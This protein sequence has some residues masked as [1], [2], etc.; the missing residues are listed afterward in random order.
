MV[1]R[2]II[3]FKKKKIKCKFKPQELLSQADVDNVLKLLLMDAE[4]VDVE[5]KWFKLLKDFRSFCTES[6]AANGSFELNGSLLFDNKYSE[7]W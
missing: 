6:N 5:L 2:I 7:K 3:I 4:F 1:N